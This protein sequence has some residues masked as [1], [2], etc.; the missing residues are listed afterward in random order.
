[1][2]ATGP[3]GVASSI[4][5]HCDHS[6]TGVIGAAKSRIAAGIRHDNDAANMPATRAPP[7]AA[8]VGHDYDAT[9]RAVARAGVTAC[10]GH[11]CDA[12]C[13]AVAR[14]GTSRIGSGDETHGERVDSGVGGVGHQATDIR[15][16]GLSGAVAGNRLRIRCFT[17]VGERR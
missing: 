5:W 1:M 6:S 16:A 17:A 14:A 7:V 11:D 13:R 15:I 12:T 10:V 8:G 2:P 9:Y 4:G 3:T